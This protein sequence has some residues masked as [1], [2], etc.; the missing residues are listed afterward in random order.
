MILNKDTASRA[1]AKI[2]R[3]EA[4]EN[5]EM[6]FKPHSGLSLLLRLD[7]GSAKEKIYEWMSTDAPD[8]MPHRFRPY[9]FGSMLRLIEMEEV[10]REVKKQQASINIG[11]GGGI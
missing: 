8:A 5:I 7:F 1:A 3:E 11:L 4:P 10:Y 9:Y 6:A 2:V